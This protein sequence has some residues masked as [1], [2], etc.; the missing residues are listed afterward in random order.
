MA[1]L[2]CLHGDPRASARVVAALGDEHLLLACP[3]WERLWE[4]LA[5]HR[6]DG[7]ILDLQDPDPEAALLRLQRLRLSHHALAIVV[8]SDFAGRELDLFHLGRLGIDGVLL[9]GADDDAGTIRRVTEQA[10]AGALAGWAAT[11]L[12]GRIDP[13]GITALRWAVEHA[14]EVPAVR[15]LAAGLGLSV[16]LLNVRLRS[17]NLPSASRILIW[18]RLL[19]AAGLMSGSG[20]TLESV[21]WKLGYANAAALRRTLRR[22]AELRPSDLT[23]SNAVESVLAAFLSACGPRP[24]RRRRVKTHPTRIPTRPP[25]AGSGTAP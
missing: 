24:R 13:V 9:A 15:D 18:G 11:R 4:V 20:T 16:E 2:A 6:V 14:R 17:G 22:H 7:C 5:T 1:V 12:E 3:G 23:L 25:P 19:R 21:A 10:L 8:H